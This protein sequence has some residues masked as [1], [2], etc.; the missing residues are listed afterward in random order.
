MTPSNSTSTKT[1]SVRNK[2]PSRSWYVD[3]RRKRILRRT[4]EL[5]AIEQAVHKRLA[6]ERYTSVIYSGSYGV[7]FTQLIGKP[8]PYV[9]AVIQQLLEEALFQDDRIKGVQ[10]LSLARGGGDSLRLSILCT[11]E[12]GEL[13]IAGEFGGDRH[14]P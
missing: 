1:L 3:Q 9:E 7:E 4:D 6:T 11:T 13:N 2:Y 14:L 5:E 10:L 12:K 8:M